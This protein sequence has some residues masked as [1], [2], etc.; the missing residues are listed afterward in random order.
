M[1]CIDVY[2]AF[3]ATR[4][5]DASI[6]LLLVFKPNIKLKVYPQQAARIVKHMRRLGLIFDTK[7]DSA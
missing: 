7:E 5:S 4:L 2:N 6:I 1:N 3:D